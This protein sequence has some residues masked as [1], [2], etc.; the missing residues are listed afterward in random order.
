MTRKRGF[1]L[2]FAAAAA[3]QAFAA[4]LPERRIANIFKPLATP[5][6]SEYDIAML[7]FAITGIIFVGVAGLIAYT[8]WRFRRP[9]DTA[10]H[11]EPPQV[12]GSNQIEVAWTVLPIL[13]VF[14]LI[15]VSAR[16]IAAVE[17][18]SPPQ[19]AL[20][21]T[22]IGHQWW[23]EVLYPD[24]NIVSA[25]EVHMPATRDGRNATYLQLQS[26]DVI[27]SF[28]IPQLSGKTDLIPNR[29]N[30]MW[31]DPKE[32]G[33][34]FGNCAEYC[35]TQH[36]NMMLRVVAEDPAAFKQWTLRQ[37]SRVVDDASVN[38]GRQEFE[39]LACINCHNINGLG[40]ASAGSK[41]GPDLTHLA[42]RQTLGAGVLKN[43]PENLRRWVNDPQVDKPGCL[44]PSMKLTPDELTKIVN[45]LETLR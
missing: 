13:I 42:S 11:Q 8:I 40:Q 2:F 21:V 41:F 10:E 36:A 25:N 19:A 43:T 6:Q 5:A 32:P 27:H 4:D 17:N 18:A 38:G 30:F 3:L 15:G 22:V 28:W 37:Q 1:R 44:M 20:K 26:A 12:Y 35:G 29:T 33:V 14:V 24:Y 39:S 23:W 9:E 34:Y 7:V 31:M 45:Y 16:V